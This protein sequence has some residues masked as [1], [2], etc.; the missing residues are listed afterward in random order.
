MIQIPTNLIGLGHR[1]LWIPKAWEESRRH[2]AGRRGSGLRVEFGMAHGDSLGSYRDC[3][4]PMGASVSSSFF[5]LIFLCL[6][7]SM[8]WE[9]GVSSE[10]QHP[11]RTVTT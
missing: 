3:T 4:K 2:R 11:E 7:P 8:L 10:G 5:F 6:L 9:V 1:P